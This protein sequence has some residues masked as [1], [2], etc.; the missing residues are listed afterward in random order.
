MIQG[1]DMVWIIRCVRCEH[2]DLSRWWAHPTEA[3]APPNWACEGCGDL[4][5]H[6]AAISSHDLHRLRKSP[7]EER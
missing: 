3:T 2:R 4:H 7:V 6:F 1:A 5:F